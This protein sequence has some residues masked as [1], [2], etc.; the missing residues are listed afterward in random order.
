LKLHSNGT[1]V[2]A[3]S[4]IQ[5]DPFANGVDLFWSGSLEPSFFPVG[6]S[7]ITV[8]YDF[9]IGRASGGNIDWRLFFANSGNELGEV[10]GTQ[11]QSNVDQQ[12]IGSFSVP[13][14]S[15][16][17]SNWSTGLQLHWLAFQADDQLR[18]NVPAGASIDLGVAVVPEPASLGVLGLG[19]VGLMVRRRRG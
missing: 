11:T 18:V 1:I 12:F 8:A 3:G 16:L 17:S 2:V 15:P 19:T 4:T 7:S 10:T 6:A 5:Q 13:V 9:T 14:T